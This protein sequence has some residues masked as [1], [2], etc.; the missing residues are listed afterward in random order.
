[1]SLFLDPVVFRSSRPL[2]IR[3]PGVR[4]NVRPDVRA[5]PVSSEEK[6]KT[7]GVRGAAAPRLNPSRGGS[8]GAKPPQPKFGGSGGQRPPA[9]TEKFSKIFR[10]ILKKVYRLC[11]CDKSFNR[12][13]NINAHIII[14]PYYCTIC[15]ACC[16]CLKSNDSLLS[17]YAVCDEEQR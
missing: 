11:L 3:W 12:V 7:R 6:K 1:M 4:P 9:K 13:Q 5:A 15:F 16:L 17:G 2:S 14:A 10:K 8:G